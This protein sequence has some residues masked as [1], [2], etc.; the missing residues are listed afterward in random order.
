MNVFKEYCFII[1][2]FCTYTLIQCP[3]SHDFTKYF[4]I[5]KIENYRQIKDNKYY[6]TFKTEISNT[7][8]FNIEL[9]IMSLI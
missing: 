3:S 4:N 9:V 1:Y 8:Y 5:E 2:R 7:S 6:N